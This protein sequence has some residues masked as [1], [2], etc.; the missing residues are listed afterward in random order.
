VWLRSERQRSAESVGDCVSV[1]LGTPRDVLHRQ[2]ERR[3]YRSSRR[4][5]GVDPGGELV[6]CADIGERERVV[7]AL[8]GSG[9]RGGELPADLPLELQR[10]PANVAEY[11]VGVEPVLVDAEVSQLDYG[12]VVSEP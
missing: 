10:V 9:V 6:Q 4:R 12:R 1:H 8:D 2:P 11:P 7:V 3:E 5:F